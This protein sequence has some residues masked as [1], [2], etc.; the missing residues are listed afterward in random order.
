MASQGHL[1]GEMQSQSGYLTGF[2]DSLYMAAFS[3]STAFLLDTFNLASM[4]ELNL[5]LPFLHEKAHRCSAAL[6]LLSAW[7]PP[8]SSA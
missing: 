3:L 7:S 2:S 1:I 4:F 8:S 5:A 6:G